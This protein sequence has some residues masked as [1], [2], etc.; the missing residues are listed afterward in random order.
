MLSFHLVVPILWAFLSTVLARMA[1]FAAYVDVVVILAMLWTDC[2]FRRIRSQV[3]F[4]AADVTMKIRRSFTE[5]VDINQALFG[6]LAIW[7]KCDGFP[8]YYHG[9]T[10]SHFLDVAVHA[11]NPA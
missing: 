8:I 4:L 5:Q 6:R 7:P 2:L 10:C 1:A 3:G 11:V 9:E